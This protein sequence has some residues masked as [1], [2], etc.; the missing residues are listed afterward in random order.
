MPE[1]LDKKYIFKHYI[2][3]MPPR[4]VLLSL[5]IASVAPMTGLDPS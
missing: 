1:K 2:S 3:G 4:G 5:S